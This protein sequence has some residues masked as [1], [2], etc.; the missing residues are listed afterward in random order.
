MISDHS[1]PLAALGGEEA[2][3]QNVYVDQ[4]SSWLAKKGHTVHVLTRQN[5]TDKPTVER[6]PDGYTVM[7]TP[8]GPEGF[9]PKEE[10]AAHLPTFTKAASALMRE[11]RY[12]IIHSHYWL[13]GIAAIALQKEFAVPVVH[14]FHSLGK[15]KHANLQKMD[16]THMRE[17]EKHELHIVK[18]ANCLLAESIDERRNL[19]RLYNANPDNITVIPAGV[20]TQTFAPKDANDARKVLGI[21]E[22]NVI[23]YV[24]RFVAQKG[25]PTLLQA[26]AQV[27]KQLT[28]TQQNN[29]ILLLVGGNVEEHTSKQSRI[30]TRIQNLI[31]SLQLEDAV[32]IEGQVNNDDLPTF[33]QAADLCVVPSRYEPF[34][35][36]PLEAMSCGIPVVASFVGGMKTTVRNLYT[37]LH[38]RPNNSADFAHKMRIL[39]LN[40]ELRKEFGIHAREHIENEF[41]WNTVCDHVLSCYNATIAHV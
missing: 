40:P 30:Q 16:A 14:T 1:D 37:G 25:I 36:V 28:T 15:I 19:L 21:T 5:N 39:L 13:S 9:L 23:L 12:D 31:T 38:A 4:L 27:R 26:Y 6:S 29:T 34:G 7:R 10:F 32:H 35:I 20:D 24:G 41:S 18:H 33:Y 22:K 2:G 11:H 8:L 3:G 17:R